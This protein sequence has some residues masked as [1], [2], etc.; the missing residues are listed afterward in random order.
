MNANVL[1]KSPLK[2]GCDM[3]TS[4]TLLSLGHRMQQPAITGNGLL[5]N[6]PKNTEKKDGR[7]ALWLKKLS[8]SQRM[9]V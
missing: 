2:S 7:M 3:K 4:I 6:H 9:R 5:A 8:F 1:F